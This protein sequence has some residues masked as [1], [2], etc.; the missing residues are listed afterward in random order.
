MITNIGK[1]IIAKYLL[2]QTQS[3]A[4]HIA[5]G[6]GAKPLS[7]SDFF[8]DYSNKGSLYFEMIRVPISSRGAITE[9]GIS[10][11]VLTAELPSEERY[12]IT[13]V[14]LY[15]A[16]S[17]P[18][19]GAYDSKTLLAFTSGESWQHHTSESALS[20][21]TISIPLD[22][23]LNDNVIA[24]T[25]KVFQTN[26]NN[27]IFYKN[28]RAQRYE[29]CRYLN[30]MIIISGDDAN[31]TP[32]LISGQFDIESGSN[33]IHLNAPGVDLTKNSP[34]DELRLA[35]SLINKDGDASTSP[36]SVRIM[37]EFANT[38]GG[39]AEYARF[40][41]ELVNGL[42]VE[43]YDFSTNRYFV[44]SK[45]LK[46]LHIT[47]SFT[48]N[49]VTVAKV[50]VSVISADTPTEDYYVA[51]DA[52]RIENLNTINPLYGLTGYSVIKNT[53]AETIVKSP[54]TNNYIEFRFVLDL[55][56]DVTS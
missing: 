10:K 32:G 11:I 38:E 54:N 9:N 50:Y 13:E 4:S 53:N 27:S 7:S 12:E 19:A 24:V 17:N 29:R 5:I 14:G 44:I 42:G 30:N 37:V 15:S 52:L 6:C 25:D 1:N 18:S 49:S 23:P 36:D 55:L 8:D 51:L 40:E 45:P 46:D 47:S 21:P 31:L 41:T 48:W 35:F 33:H 56:G 2:G 43:E 34:M 39:S 26:A 16:G 22:N 3:Y 20:I 28:S